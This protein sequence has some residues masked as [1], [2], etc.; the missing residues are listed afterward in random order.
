MGFVKNIFPIATW[1]LKLKPKK[2]QE[3]Q[4]Q[5]KLLICKIR[6]STTITSFLL[7]G[8]S[9][10]EDENCT[11][12]CYGKNLT[13]STELT[14]LLVEKD[15][16]CTNSSKTTW[17]KDYHPSYNIISH[18]CEGYVKIN[19]AKACD[20]VNISSSNMRRICY[21]LRPSKTSAIS[22]L[23]HYDSSPF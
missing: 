3:Y 1:L 4:A 7:I 20:K 22:Y 18:S 5:P 17:S 11:S 19:N 10:S 8:T 16:N 21:C 2:I 14:A 23:W 6:C 12:H 9:I 13:C 15:I